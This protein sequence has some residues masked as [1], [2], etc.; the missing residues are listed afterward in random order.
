M[1]HRLRRLMKLLLH[2]EGTPHTTALAF[3]IGVWIAWSPL[4]GIH[5]VLALGI[6][7]LFR[8]NR[9]AILVGTYVNNPW[10]IAPLY[11]AGT[12][13]GCALLGVSPRDLVSPDWSS[14]GHGFSGAALEGVRVYLWPFVVGNTVLGAAGGFVGYA[15]LKRVLEVRSYQPAS[16]T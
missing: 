13:L 8:L 4:L 2:V 16:G 1:K 3:G 10:T 6:A 5:T 14:M 9:V 7:F 12:T 11:M 15:I